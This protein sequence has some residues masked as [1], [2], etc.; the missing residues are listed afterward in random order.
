[1]HTYSLFELNEYIRRVVAL[2]FAEPI[3]I[4]CE[5]AQIKEARGNFY[6][7]LVEQDESDQVIAQIQ[8]AIWYKN[9]LFIK[10]KLGVL[11]QSLLVAGTHI[12][13]KVS[14]DFNERYGLKL[15]VEDIDPTYT[16]GRLELNR[17]KIIERLKKEE[18]VDQNKALIL[19]RVI[20]SIAVISSDTAAGYQ[21]FIKHMQH[22]AYGYSFEIT[23]FKAAMQGTNTEREVCAALDEITGTGN[24]DIIAL[25]RGGGSKL[26]LSFFDNFN[27]GFKIASS[28]IPVFTGIGHEIDL[29]VADMV[30][31]KTL[32][33]PTA[34]ADYILEHNARFEGEI[35]D[36]ETRMHQLVRSLVDR[37]HRE[38]V[39]SEQTLI[40]RPRE[41]IATQYRE[42]EIIK[43]ISSQQVKFIFNRASD[44][45]TAFESLIV[46]YDP[47]K[48]LKRGFAIVHQNGEIIDRASKAKRG[49]MQIEF[50]DQ[51]ITTNYEH[52]K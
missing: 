46:S 48:V 39:L 40:Q 13:I 36:I 21:D 41:I 8:A 29:S 10:S 31:N 17:Q 12:K 51:T 18:V 52:K 32:K 35:I 7:D 49:L 26:D 20:Q 50:S 5:I 47:Q 2:N 25:M 44:Q 3:W 27:I 33:T 22:N 1:M 9:Y 11:T 14:V 45:I 16:L 19:P 30:S 6:L 34:V 42:L 37:A 43:S 28:P 23:L 4:N 15:L 24:F 38:L